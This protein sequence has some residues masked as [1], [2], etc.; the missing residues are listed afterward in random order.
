MSFNDKHPNHQR[1]LSMSTLEK[2][3]VITSKDKINFNEDIVPVK[4][5]NNSLIEI[6]NNEGG[7]IETSREDEDKIQNISHLSDSI[8]EGSDVTNRNNTNQHNQDRVVNIST[9]SFD[10]IDNHPFLGSLILKHTRDRKIT[11]IDGQQRL[12]TISLLAKAI[13]DTLAS[14]G[15]KL[16]GSGIRK[17]IESY[18]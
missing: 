11:I 17:D 6:S 14:H 15:Y 4:Q 16:E 5:H 13:Y 3:K 7:L 9:I 8:F 10:N 2:Q 18:A 1:S 12:T